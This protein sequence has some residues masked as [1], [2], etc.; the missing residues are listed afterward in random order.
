MTTTT[1]TTKRETPAK[2]LE[3]L[4][5]F[6]LDYDAAFGEGVE[7]AA[8]GAIRLLSEPGPRIEPSDPDAA[9]ALA[10][11]SALGELQNPGRDSRAV[12]RS[13]KGDYSYDYAGL[14]A[15]LADVR[16]VLAR[17]GLAI[18][19]PVRG[20]ADGLVT[21]STKIIHRLGKAYS[22][23]PIERVVAGGPQE[24][25]SFVTYARRYA[26]CALLGIHPAGEDDD[27]ATAQPSRGSRTETEQK[28][29]LPDLDLGGVKLS[30]RTDDE[31]RELAESP[32]SARVGAL[33]KAWL[34]RREAEGPMKVE[35]DPT[36]EGSGA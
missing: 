3:R 6:L 2:Q 16:P 1:D 26:L 5:T 10:F 27:G 7:S 22:G 19:Q 36:G 13:Q 33:A 4:S 31:L 8:D 28:D 15:I 35:L 24:L 32:P 20:Q 29:E 23:E 21:V 11:V 12:V 34:S 30:Q 14:D 17:H 9:L 18:S 25:G